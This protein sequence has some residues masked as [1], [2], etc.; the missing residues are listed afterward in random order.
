[1]A[2]AKLL[3]RPGNLLLL[4]EPTNH[5]DLDSCES[6]IESLGGFGGTMVFV[7]HNRALIRKLANKIWVVE[8]GTVT[9]YMG[10][11]DD[12][13]QR[14]RQK[15]QQA[16]KDAAATKA[17]T[18]AAKTTPKTQPPPK[19]EAPKQAAP[20]DEKQRR[21]EEA[22]KRDQRNKVIAPLK[23]KVEEL[24]ARIAEIETKQAERNAKLCDTTATLTD[25]ER[26]ALLDGLQVDQTKLD[27]L[28]ER[29][30]HTQKELDE[31]ERALSS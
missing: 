18:S 23:K 30:E 1:V 6:L 10:S 5:L 9:E 31:K 11:L 13:M 27:E 26:Y 24:E 22:Q 4:D 19:M 28:T 20:V 8:G 16:A 12:Y 17:P 21:R 3:V 7:S 2:L 14:E 25:K 15:L 29:W